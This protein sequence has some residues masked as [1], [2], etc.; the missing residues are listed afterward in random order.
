MR[1]GVYRHPIKRLRRLAEVVP[2]V[3]SDGLHLRL[4]AHRHPSD[5]VNNVS[6]A[7][8]QR[9]DD[10][11]QEILMV[12]TTQYGVRAHG[13]ILAQ[14]MSGSGIEVVMRC[15]RRIRDTGTQGHMWAPGL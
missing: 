11:C 13:N 8:T 2:I 14:A 10:W 7:N 6:S 4:R 1:P 5:V 12:E 9:R 15:R 3:A